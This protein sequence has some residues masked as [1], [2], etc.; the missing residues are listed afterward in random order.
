M[1]LYDTFIFF[2]ELDL[3][4]IRL[5]LLYEHVHAF[6]LVEGQET[7]SGK[8]KPMHF[9]ENKERFAQWSDKIRHVKARVLP[10]TA[11]AWDREAAAR[12]DIGYGLHDADGEDLVYMSD[13]DELWNPEKALEG[14]LEQRTSFVGP[15]SY[16]YVNMVGHRGGGTKRIR[17]R[18]WR[19]GDE[20][21][22]THETQRIE[23][24]HWHF[25]YLGG[26]DRIRHKIDSYSHQELNIPQFTDPNKLHAAIESGTDL[27]GRKQKWVVQPIDNTYPWP[28]VQQQE[29]YKHLIRSWK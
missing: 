6:I 20:L 17:R 7:F 22:K 27:F 16:Y 18:M 23:D 10:R 26:V 28:I 8:P 9:L 13:A 14:D 25:S 15:V 24:A 12:N 3:L 29:K 21:R 19:G 11:G 1:K 4:E 2:N 5:Q